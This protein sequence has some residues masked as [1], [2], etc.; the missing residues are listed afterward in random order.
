MNDIKNV[1]KIILGDY[2]DYEQERSCNGG[3]YAYFTTFKRIDDNKWE[4]TYSTT[5]EFEYCLYMG[6]FQSCK[7][8]CLVDSEGCTPDV[9]TDKMVEEEISVWEEYQRK[10]GDE[11]YTIHYVIDNKEDEDELVKKMLN[12]LEI[13]SD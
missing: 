8:C 10:Y 1:K 6:R 4:V 7:D 2:T 11:E 9:Y 3:C 12:G 5:S 13:G